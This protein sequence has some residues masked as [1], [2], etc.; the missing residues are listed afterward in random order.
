[1]DREQIAR[2]ARKAKA[3]YH[4][5]HFSHYPS[6]DVLRERTLELLT[7]HIAPLLRDRARDERAWI[8]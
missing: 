2:M 6:N 8:A 4:E 7:D 1:M 3:I 5:L